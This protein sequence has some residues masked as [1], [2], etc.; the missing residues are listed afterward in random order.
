MRRLQA[1]PIN[2]QS[3]IISNYHKIEKWSKKV[4]L[5]LLNLQAKPKFLKISKPAGICWGTPFVRNSSW[6]T[7][8]S[9]M[10]PDKYVAC[11][12]IQNM[13]VK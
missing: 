8:Q 3:I 1:M 5:K 7:L 9:W 10:I 6:G 2:L 11:I 13:P 4:F 12:V